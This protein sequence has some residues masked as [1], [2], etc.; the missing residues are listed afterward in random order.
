MRGIGHCAVGRQNFRAKFRIPPGWHQNV[1][2]P[3]VPTDD[4]QNRNRHDPL[5]GFAPSD[6]SDF[7]RKVATLWNIDLAWE[8]ELL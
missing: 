1:C 4:H 5:P 6:F 3:N 7:V 8:E 2:D